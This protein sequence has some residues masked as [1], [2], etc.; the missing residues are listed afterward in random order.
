[1]DDVNFSVTDLPFM[2]KHV[3]L[4]TP[5][6]TSMSELQSCVSTEAVFV[7]GPLNSDRFFGHFK[8]KYTP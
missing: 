3:T 4:T 5:V 7:L 8:Q 1:M 2:W 6:I